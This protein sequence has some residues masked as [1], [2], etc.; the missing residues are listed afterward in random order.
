[1]V[2][3]NTENI[4][5]MQ[6]FNQEDIFNLI[7]N[8]NWSAILT[9]LH[10]NK[11]VI[12][13]DTLLQYSV[14]I[15]K[16]EFFKGLNKKEG[17]I[18]LDDLD[19]LFLLQ[20]G[21][22]IELSKG[23]YKKLVCELAYRSKGE[24][25]Y[26]YAILFPNDPKCKGI[27][28]KKESSLS[29]SPKK[30]IKKMNWIEIY[31]R[32]FEII[33]VQD[34]A[35]TYFS[36]PRFI[37]LLKKIDKYHPDYKQY[38]D[39]RNQEGK[40]TSRRIYYYDILM[41]LE[42]NDRINFVNRIIEIVEP[43]E[44]EKIIPIK[45]LFK[46]KRIESLKP[47]PKVKKESDNIETVFISYSWDDID[48]KEWVLILANN[49]ITNGVNVI[50]DRYELGLGKSLPFFVE[51]SIKV[52]DRIVIILTP[53]YKKKAENRKGGV[54]Y[55]YSIMNSELY[56][57]QTNNDRI[58]P[59]LRKGNSDESIPD[60]IKQY[61]HLD[62]SNDE[63]YENSFNDLLREIYDEPEIIKPILGNRKSFAR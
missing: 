48:H 27:I 53:N 30:T 17:I 16:S 18:S 61:I 46:G 23:N 38:I 56:N 6:S 49:L 1:V 26:N 36:G 43:F 20:S 54:G 8:K 22:F 50:L 58:I 7:Q 5:L 52:A 4:K 57:N 37:K 15:F 62:M 44:I 11:A 40:S 42:E 59:V 34:D 13:S 28:N 33:N 10:K 3:I 12:K 47:K 29:K 25:A 35:R 60:F 39:I 51:Q 41:K 9:F 2:I 24:S 32:I 63:K 19:N 45:N 55:E 31:N 21:D 14:S